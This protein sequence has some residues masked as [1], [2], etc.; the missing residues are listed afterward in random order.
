M[1]STAET[2]ETLEFDFANEATGTAELNPSYTFNKISIFFDM[3]VAGADG[4]DGTFYF[5]DID[6][7]P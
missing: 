5:D 1:L 2:W 4:G 6:M 3:G 7:A